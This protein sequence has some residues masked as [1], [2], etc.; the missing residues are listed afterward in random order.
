[1]NHFHK[2]FL[3]ILILGLTLSVPVIG[4]SLIIAIIILVHIQKYKD[5]NP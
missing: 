1:M 4:T 3:I 5:R 2:A